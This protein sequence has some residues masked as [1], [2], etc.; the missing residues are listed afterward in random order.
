M[1]YRECVSE[2]ELNII[3]GAR[4]NVDMAT[5]EEVKQA[6]VREKEADLN[7]NAIKSMAEAAVHDD[8]VRYATDE[9]PNMNEGAADENNLLLLQTPTDATSGEVRR[10]GEEPVGN[11]DLF[12]VDNAVLNV[13]QRRRVRLAGDVLADVAEEFEAR[14]ANLLRVNGGG[15]EVMRQERPNRTFR[16]WMQRTL[17]S[18]Q[19]YI[20]RNNPRLTWVGGMMG[21]TLFVLLIGQDNQHVS[22]YGGGSA[23]G[24]G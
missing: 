23:C 18:A 5:E 2:E 16:G 13:D 15:V 14:N 12:A 19:R 11:V 4:Q 9:D 22:C 21:A 20:C 10:G 8:D 24:C 17:G 1:A 7:A 3:V 6:L